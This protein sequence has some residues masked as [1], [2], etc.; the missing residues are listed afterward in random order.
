MVAG[1]EGQYPSSGFTFLGAEVAAG[2]VLLGIREVFFV[3][4][5]V[6]D[7]D[8]E[9]KLGLVPPFL[10]SRGNICITEETS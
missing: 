1:A 2:V 4:V 8:A 9:N 7:D 5:V 3:E 6:G 10:L